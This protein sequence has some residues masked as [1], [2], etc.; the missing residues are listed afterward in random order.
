MQTLLSLTMRVGLL[1]ALLFSA[2]IS[3]AAAAQQEQD[4]QRPFILPFAEPPGPD[5]WLLG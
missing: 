2:T 1:L 4:G 3:Q 5:T